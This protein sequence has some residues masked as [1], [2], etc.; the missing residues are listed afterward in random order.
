MTIDFDKI[1][2]GPK[3]G[4]YIYGLYVDGAKWDS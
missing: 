1:L 2:A 3:D 4:V